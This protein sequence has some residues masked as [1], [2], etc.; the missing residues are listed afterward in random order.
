MRSMMIKAVFAAALPL[1]LAAPAMADETHDKLVAMCQAGGDKPETCE[2]QVKALEENVDA[3]V[4]QVL[5]AMQDASVSATTP[6]AAE[7]AM[8]DALA[9]AG[10]TKEEFEKAL[11]DA[12]AKVGPAME[13]CKAS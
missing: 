5:A 4:L 12:E 9:A 8:A 7:K 6:E 13:A 2:C 11:G 3:K 10:L 1:F